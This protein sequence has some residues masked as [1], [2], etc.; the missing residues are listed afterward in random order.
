MDQIVILFP[1][2]HGLILYKTTF[3]FNLLAISL[4]FVINYA[5][6]CCKFGDKKCFKI[7]LFEFVVYSIHKYFE[8]LDT[9]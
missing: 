1:F 2:T 6:V 9:T 3:I 5:G 4:T 7:C 8:N